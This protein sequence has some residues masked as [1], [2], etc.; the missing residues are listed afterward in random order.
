MSQKISVGWGGGELYKTIVHRNINGGGG[1]GGGGGGK[2]KK[3][4][5]KRR[6]KG[7]E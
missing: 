2:K 6:T 5:K 7:K 3:K 1:G 4:E